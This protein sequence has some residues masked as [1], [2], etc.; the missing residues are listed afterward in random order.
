MME[1]K[2]TFIFNQSAPEPNSFRNQAPNSFIEQVN[3]EDLGIATQRN[4]GRVRA[5]Q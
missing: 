4:K 2:I 5:W 1:P 3:S